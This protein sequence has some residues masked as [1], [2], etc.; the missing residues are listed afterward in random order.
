MKEIE[1]RDLLV[2][3]EL[4]TQEVADSKSNLK[5]VKELMGSLPAL[6]LIIQYQGTQSNSGV[7]LLKVYVGNTD[8]YVELTV[9]SEVHTYELGTNEVFDL[10]YEQDTPLTDLVKVSTL[11]EGY[12]NYFKNILMVIPS[13]V[14][15]SMP[16]LIKEVE[17]EIKGTIEAML[18]EEVIDIISEVNA[19]GKPVYS[20]VDVAKLTG[21]TTHKVK[22]IVK[23]Y[24]A[25]LP[26]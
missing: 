14:L 5:I 26:K 24:K 6:P 19:V 25:T 1:L 11:S 22:Q 17:S 9:P 15:K 21:I 13:N 12:T 18:A 10:M 2:E 7:S 16:N 8:T 4:I 20:M 23:A 3:K